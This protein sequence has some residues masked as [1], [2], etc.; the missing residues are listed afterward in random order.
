MVS[1][2]FVNVGV[3]NED[4]YFVHSGLKLA[5]NSQLLNSL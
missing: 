3:T 4:M 5:G 2:C 1:V